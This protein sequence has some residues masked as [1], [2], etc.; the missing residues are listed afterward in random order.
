MR[1]RDN[2]SDQVT[3]AVLL[4]AG[5]GTRLQ[6][7]TFDAPKCLTE[8]NGTPILE[9]QVLSLLEWGFDRLVV[10]VGHME[11]CIRKFL[12]KQFNDLQIEYVVN[13]RYH[14]TG[15]LYSLWL[16]LE[17]IMEPFLLASIL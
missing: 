7:L 16:V 2:G 1:R 12:D 6:P 10:V 11:N 14:T 9:H 8:I 4:A 3:T 5:A 17:K 15:N 13:P